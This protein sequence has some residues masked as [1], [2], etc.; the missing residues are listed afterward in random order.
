MRRALAALRV[1]MRTLDDIRREIEQSVERR[2]ELYDALAE[3]HDAARADEAA[4]LTARIAELWDEA[5]LARVRDRFGAPDLIIARA[6]AEERLD[7]ESR[8]LKQ[9]A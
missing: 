4:Q 5:R 9:A 2:A 7:R 1:M 3:S 6:R 8:R